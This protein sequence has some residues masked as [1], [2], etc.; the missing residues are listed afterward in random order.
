MQA[1]L[2]YPYY[3]HAAWTDYENEPGK[4]KTAGKKE[5]KET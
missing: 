1:V 2:R 5:F 4:I 3:L